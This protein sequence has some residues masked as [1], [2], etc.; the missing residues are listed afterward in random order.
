MYNRIEIR[1]IKDI[2]KG[3]EIT[4]C[5]SLGTSTTFSDICTSEERKMFIKEEFGLECK[6]CAC[7]DLDK[8]QENI[9]MELYDHIQTLSSTDIYSKSLS[10][11]ARDAEKLDKINDLTQK[12]QICR[13]QVE[14][15]DFTGVNSSVGQESESRDKRLE[16]VEEV[17]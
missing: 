15:Y 3:E 16:H 9:A 1:A 6:C 10:E 8:D 14:V 7:S 12:F 13:T 5:V 17:F 4:W 11:W 2:S